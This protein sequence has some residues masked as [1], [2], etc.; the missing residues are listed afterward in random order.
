MKTQNPP[1]RGTVQ[2][3]KGTTAMLCVSVW[4]R[5]VAN[6]IHKREEEEKKTRGGGSLAGACHPPRQSSSSLVD[7]WREKINGRESERRRKRKRKKAR[8]Q[9]DDH[10]SSLREA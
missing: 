3:H 8:L 2:K 1:A 7:R 4:D 10:A 5:N 9:C 6:T